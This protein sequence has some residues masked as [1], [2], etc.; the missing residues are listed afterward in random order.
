MKKEII[1][2]AAIALIST[3]TAVSCG[4]EVEQDSVSVALPKVTVASGEQTTTG[5]GTAT[6]SKTTA[7]AAVVSGT[8]SSTTK[9]DDDEKDTETTA[10]TEEKT[11]EDE[12]PVVEPTEK[13]TEA[14]TEARRATGTGVRPSSIDQ[15]FDSFASAYGTGYVESVVP[16]CIPKGDESDM[17]VYDYSG[18]TIQC[19]SSGGVKYVGAIHITGSNYATPEGVGI[20]SSKSDVEAAYGSGLVQGSGNILYRGAYNLEFIMNGDTVSEIDYDLAF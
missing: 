20:G 10:A 7:T 8:G 3:M 12:T 17:Y 13:A 15:T 6:T 4:R 19:Y 2:I 9:S 18:M 16:S 11:D 5:T 14:P 1:A